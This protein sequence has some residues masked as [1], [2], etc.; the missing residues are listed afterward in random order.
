MFGL[1]CYGHLSIK[2]F[3]QY[4]LCT[5]PLLLPFPSSPCLQCQFNYSLK[6]QLIIQRC[7][8]TSHKSP[9]TDIQL[10]NIPILSKDIA[11]QFAYHFYRRQQQYGC[12]MLG[13]RIYYF[14]FLHLIC[15][16]T[17]GCIIQTILNLLYCMFSCVSTGHTT[18]M[19]TLGQ[20]EFLEAQLLKDQ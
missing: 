17:C 18:S 9:T 3:R 5:M 12:N 7:C 11:A 8:Q 2:Y 4:M 6:L 20:R 10:F 15:L 16:K 1:K 14:Y 13:L 19:W